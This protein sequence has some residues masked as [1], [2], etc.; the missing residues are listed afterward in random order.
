[1]KILADSIKFFDTKR[2]NTK[3][4]YRENLLIL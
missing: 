2:A 4:G 1:M 3:E